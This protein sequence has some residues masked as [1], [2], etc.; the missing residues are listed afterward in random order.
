[1]RREI[2]YI[3][4]PALALLVSCGGSSGS[5]S[6]PAPTAALTASP[7]VVASG[8]QATLSWT[9]TNAATCAASG[10][11]SGTLATSGSQTEG[12]L[13]SN[14]TYSL[15]CSSSSGKASSAASATVNVTPTVALTASPTRIMGSGS[16]TLS[17]SSTNATACTASDRKSVV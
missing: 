10:G 17:W 4:L 8:G 14:T 13:T 3:L 9:S 1:M 6:D 2:N 5:G 15:T 7:T 16:A 12:P 11:W